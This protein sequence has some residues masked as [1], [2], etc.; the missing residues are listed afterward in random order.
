MPKIPKMKRSKSLACVKVKKERGEEVR[1]ALKSANLLRTDV[2][3]KHDANFVY[4]PLTEGHKAKEV[5]DIDMESVELCRTEFEVLDINPGIEE[6]IGFKPSYEIVGDI[7][8]LDESADEAVASAIMKLHKNIRVVARRKS[9]VEGVFRR[10]RIEIIA[11]ER[12]T[13]TVHK[14]NGCRYKLDLER[15][16]FNPRLA[17]ERNRV[18]SLAA[19]S[20]SEETIIDMFAG[21]GPFSILIA[22]RAVKSHIIAIDI[23]PDAIKYLRE[24]IR[25]NAVE[26]VEPI[27]GDV[28]A[29]YGAFKD[30]A[31]RIIMNL[32]KK[33]YLFLPEAV[34]MLKPEGGTIHF[35]MV[36]SIKKDEDLNNAKH[37][38]CTWLSELG[39]HTDPEILTARKVK[40]YAPRRYIIGIDAR[41]FREI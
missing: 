2:K 17:T 32:P 14:E 7:A 13:E 3:I 29:I 12:R 6:L 1:R 34:Q 24:N 16:Y 15:V 35:Y 36:E 5:A 8:V 28:K 26:N 25:L 41:V 9:H 4:L 10:R 40:A 39:A 31:D 30:K 38:F 33:A 20:A 18:A 37:K 23:N 21:V 22:K 27:E 19:R 11:G